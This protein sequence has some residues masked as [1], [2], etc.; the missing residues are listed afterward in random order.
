MKGSRIADILQAFY[1]VEQ[2]TKNV[3]LEIPTKKKL[4]GNEE[5]KPGTVN[6]Q[7]HG[8]FLKWGVVLLKKY[9]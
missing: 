3:F 1:H 9:L 4:Q 7:P 2:D 5:Y 8:S 6:S